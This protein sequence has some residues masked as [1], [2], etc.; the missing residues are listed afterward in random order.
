MKKLGLLGS[1]ALLSFATPAFA[2]DVVGTVVDASDTIALR[3]AEVRIVELNRTATTQ[4]DGRFQF[5]DVPAGEYNLEARYFGAETVRKTLVVPAEGTVAVGLAIGG[6]RSREILVLGQTASQASALSRQKAADGVKSVLTRDAIGQFPDQNVAE[7]L[8]RLPGINILNDQGEGRFVSVR[9]LDPDLNSSSL[10]GVRLPAPESDVRAVA[11]DVISS[12]IIESIEVKK[13][14][15]P[16]MDADTIG[17]SIEINTTSA[18]D[19]KKPLL[20][21]RVE[22]SWND[23]SNK[24]TPKLGLDFSTRIGDDF[25]VAGGLSYYKRQFETDNIETGGPWSTAGNGVVFA[26]EVQFRDYDITRKRISA[27]LSFDWRVSDSTTAYIRGNWSQFDDH[28]YRRRTTMIFNEDPASGDSNSAF[29]YDADG[30]IEV[31]RDMKD[32][33]ERQRIRSIVAGSKTD[34][35]EWKLDWAA[36]YAKSTEQEDFSLDPTRFRARFDGDGVG[37]NWDYTNRRIPSYSVTSGE[38]LFNDPAEYGFNRIELTDLSDSQD[39]EYSLQANMAHVSTFDNGEFTIQAGAKGRWRKKSYDFN[40]LFYGDYNGDYSL[41]DVLGKQTYR[42][43]NIGPVSS[44]TGPTAFYLANSGNFEIDD[45]ETALASSIDDYAVKEDVTAAYLLG[46]WDSSDLRVIGGVRVERTKTRMVGNL[47]VDAEPDVI[48]SSVAFNRSYTDWLPSLTLRYQPQPELV[49]R[50][51]GYKSLV[52]PKLSNLAPRYTINDSDEAEFGNPELLPYKAFN[53]DAGV[54]Y[55]YSN[56]GAIILGGFYKKID[57]FIVEGTFDAADAPYNGVYRGT[58][59]AEAVIPVNGKSAKVAGLEA[60]FNQAMRFLPAPFDGLLVQANYTYTWSEGSLFDGR[61]ISLP[62]NSR[63]TFNIVLGYDK[64]PVDLRVAGAYRS[65]ML[66][67]IG[68]GADTDRYADSHFQID[69]SAK[70]KLTENVRVYAEWVNV[71][72][73]KYF[74]YHNYAGR[75]RL[76]QY[77]QFGSTV[78]FGVRAN[79]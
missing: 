59:F 7:S 30:R 17:A 42:L 34:T 53:L 58:A 61:K 19:R 75:Q 67:E 77:D 2:G 63:N 29:F 25:G 18:F 26:D 76:L 74:A 24:L 56:D 23:Y 22:G 41:A 45:Y 49:L 37:V 38:S 5:N 31:R 68:S 70:Y 40:L 11:L 12:D 13:S 46:R 39:R 50:L 15:T 60:S 3:A 21:A 62:S 66:E 14:L 55:Y 32:R 47:V 72:N 27:A 71:N 69:I 10:N 43:T 35:G 28:E 20:A 36:S 78:K 4:A 6:E 51:A 79:F 48:V 65:K 8:R 73:A 1:T 16:D 33:F 44:K 57:N 9:G 54:E 52:R 64:G